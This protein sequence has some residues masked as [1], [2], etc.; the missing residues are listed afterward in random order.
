[1]D[2]AISPMAMGTSQP[3]TEP[4]VAALQ[5]TPFDTGLDLK[6]L[7]VISSYFSTLREKYLKNGLLDPKVLKVNVNALLYQ[8][9]GGMLSNL[10][11]QLKQM[12]NSE[13]LQECLEEVPRVRADAGYPPLVTP[14]SQIVGTQAVMNVIYGERYKSVTKEFKGLVRGEYGKTAVP[15]DPEFQKKILGDETP[16]TCR[17][18]DL[19]KPELEELKKKC[20]PYM[21]QDE[22][23]LSYA[24]F[25]QVATKFFEQRKAAKLG[26]DAGNADS[27]NKIHTV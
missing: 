24:L 2:T 15:I 9:P 20:A 6:K 18:A 25:E 3:P 7:D 23:I 21:E 12:G 5:G 1:M 17:P 26:I 8:V 11:S 13:K 10:I 4:M 19:L 14:S 27:A 22:D 16:I